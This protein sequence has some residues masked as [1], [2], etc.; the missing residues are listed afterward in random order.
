MLDKIRAIA[1]EKLGSEEAANAFMEGFEKEAMAGASSIWGAMTAPDTIGKAGVG[2]A[3]SLLGAGIV[4]GVSKGFGVVKD[5]NL[6]G[7]FDMALAQVMAS[8][9]IVK[10]ARP[11]RV[12]EYAETMFRFAPHVASDPNLLGSILANAVLGESIDPQT[13]KTLVDLEGRYVDNNK[14]SPLAGIKH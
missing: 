6:R 10:Q 12:K 5:H 8:N 14:I 13:I 2:L 7:K 4:A 1:L 3:A 11:E 9:K